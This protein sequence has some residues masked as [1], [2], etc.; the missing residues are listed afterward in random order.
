VDEAVV[1]AVVEGITG[2]VVG[3]EE[4][5]LR[6]GRPRSQRKRTSWIYQNIW[7]SGSMSSSTVEERVSWPLV[8]M[9]SCM[10]LM[11]MC[12]CGH[13]ERLRSAHEPSLR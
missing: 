2:V 4:E 10:Q 9:R 12:S 8:H 13:L 7:I 6:E 3:A 5:E 1:E 11:V